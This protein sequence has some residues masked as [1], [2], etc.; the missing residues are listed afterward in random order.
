MT[1]GKLDLIAAE[2]CRKLA[3]IDQHVA[4]HQKRIANGSADQFDEERW[5]IVFDALSEVHDLA[6]QP[7]PLEEMTASDLHSIE[8]NLHQILR[9]ARRNAGALTSAAPPQSRRRKQADA[10]TTGYVEHLIDPRA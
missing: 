6:R 7:V 10:S 9:W 5:Q 3:L 1:K 8:A 2:V 4:E